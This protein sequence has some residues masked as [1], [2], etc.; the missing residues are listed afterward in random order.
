MTLFLRMTSGV[1]HLF[2]HRDSRRTMN[3]AETSLAAVGC[4]VNGVDPTLV[5]ATVDRTMQ[6]MREF[7]R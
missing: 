4:G 5:F 3:T 7:S 2:P 1:I 6:L